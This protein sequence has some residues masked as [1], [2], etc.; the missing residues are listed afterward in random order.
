M[1]TY[2]KKMPNLQE[3]TQPH[4]TRRHPNTTSPPLTL[5]AFSAKEEARKAEVISV[6]QVALGETMAI[7]LFFDL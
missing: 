4:F 2:K 1:K 5:P 7:M 3:E 6:R